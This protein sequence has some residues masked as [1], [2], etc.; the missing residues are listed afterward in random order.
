MRGLQTSEY[1]QKAPEGYMNHFLVTL[2]NIKKYLKE[3]FNYD[4][5]DS[6]IKEYFKE[7]YDEKE[8]SFIFYS[9]GWSMPP[10]VKEMYEENGEY[11]IELSETSEFNK[12]GTV[13]LKQENNQFYFYSSTG[14]N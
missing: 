13:V 1:N 3:N 2:S 9:T 11:Y 5:S 7:Y 4:Y 6:E 12:K 10:F 14:L 8:K